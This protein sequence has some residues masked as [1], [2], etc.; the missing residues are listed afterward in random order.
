MDTSQNALVASRSRAVI[1]IG[2][3][4]LP[5]AVNWVIFGS[6]AANRSASAAKALTRM[7][8]V[9]D[10]ALGVGALTSVKEHTQGPEWLSMGA[11]ADGIDALVLLTARGVPRRAR[12]IGVGAAASAVF[13][14]KLSRDLADERALE[15]ALAASA[16]DGS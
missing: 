9:R 16:E 14:M 3:M 4:L 12:V 13:I 1:G 10:F 2:A 5:G 7:L 15:A 11:L 8:G 6:G